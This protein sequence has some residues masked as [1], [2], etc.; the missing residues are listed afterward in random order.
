[1]SKQLSAVVCGLMLVWPLIALGSGSYS[2]RP[3]SAV[4]TTKYHLGKQIFTGARLDNELSA[5]DSQ[6][7][8]RLKQLQAL[9]PQPAQSSVNLPQLAGKL[10]SA[11]LNALEYYLRIRYRIEVQ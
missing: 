9:L 8:G 2:S 5:S 4:S 10:N 3:S 11:Q 6:Q 1:M 7:G